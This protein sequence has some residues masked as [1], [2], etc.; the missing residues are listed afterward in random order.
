MADISNASPP[1]LPPLFCIDGAIEEILPRLHDVF[2]NDF[3]RNHPCFET[4]PVNANCAIDTST[5]HN[6]EVGFWHIIGHYDTREYDHQRAIRLPWCSPCIENSA[7]SI[8]TRWNYQ[9]AS[10]KI[11]TYIWL[12][13]FRY[14]IILQHG[15][16]NRTG[17]TVMFLITAFYVNRGK[18]AELERKY[19][20][21]YIA[22]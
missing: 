1:W 21:R 19:T 14:L 18:E 2:V 4:I 6:Y 13:E 15:T 12:R 17:E 10:G 22:K 8:V 9:E 20:Q 3:K 5:D 16:H 7:N 11:R